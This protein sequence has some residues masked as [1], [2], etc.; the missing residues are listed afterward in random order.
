MKELFTD[1]WTE[2]LTIKLARTLEKT[3]EKKLYEDS[4]FRLEMKQ[5]V[6]SKKDRLRFQSTVK[7]MMPLI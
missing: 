1:L 4:M 7:A 5:T 3:K 6:Q 2:S